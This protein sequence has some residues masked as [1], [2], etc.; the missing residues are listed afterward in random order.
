MDPTTKTP[1]DL[2]AV[3]NIAAAL[4]PFKTDDQERIIRWAREKVGL[5]IPA[6]DTNTPEKAASGP[7]PAVPKNNAPAPQSSSNIKQFVEQKAPKSDMHFATVVAYYHRFNAP[8][9]ER[10]NTVTAEDLQDACRKADRERL[11]HPGQTLINAFNAGLL[12][13]EDRGAFAINSVGE[14]LVAMALPEPSGG[15]GSSKRKPTKIK[16]KPAKRK[17]KRN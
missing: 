11:K 17:Q 1:D 6:R 10:R 12:D 8:A 3:R 4:A 5:S 14:N 7:A 9:G 13:R 2:E 15:A 16:L